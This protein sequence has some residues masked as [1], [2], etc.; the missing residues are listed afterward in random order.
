MRYSTVQYW[1]DIGPQVRITVVRD[2]FEIVNH[3]LND[4]CIADINYFIPNILNCCT[5]NLM[6]VA[7]EPWNSI[8]TPLNSS[9][10]LKAI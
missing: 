2:L 4:V 10:R 6:Q 8:S 1:L 9:F 3:P 5:F 7:F